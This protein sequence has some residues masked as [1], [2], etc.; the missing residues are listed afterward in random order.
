MILVELHL[1]NYKQYAGR[2]LIEF[3]SH[4]A[5][6]II[7]NNGA[8]K[9]T[10]F[11]AIEWCLYN[12][13]HIPT[14]EIPPRGGVGDTRVKL[15]L[16]DPRDGVRYVIERVR[17]RR[18]VEAEI[19]RADQPDVLIVKGSRD[20]T[21]YVK[22][23]LIGLGHRAFVSTF[24]TRQKELSFFGDLKET[25]RRRE[26]AQLLG[27]ETIRAAQAILG[28]DRKAARDDALLLTRQYEEERKDHDFVAEAAQAEAAI[29]AANAASRVAAEQIA[30]REAGLAEARSELERWNALERDD[31]AMASEIERLAGNLRA[32]DT[33]YRNAA[34]NLARLDALELD[35]QALLPRRDAEPAAHERLLTLD[36]DHERFLR[37]QS[38]AESARR[39]RST[40]DD[41]IRRARQVVQSTDAQ[42]LSLPGWL[43]DAA[44]DARPDAGLA[45]LIK[46]IDGLDPP[47]AAD[48]ADKLAALVRAID[49]LTQSQ[50]KA[51]QYQERLRHV[52]DDLAQK[53]ANGDPQMR[54]DAL[55]LARDDAHRAS[56]TALT[57][58]KGLATR[59]KELERT[60]AAIRSAAKQPECPTCRR[61]LPIAEA[62]TA[63]APLISQIKD[64]TEQQQRSEAERRTAQ[65]Q[66]TSAEAE[67]EQERARLLEIQGL[68]A[69][70]N[71]GTEYVRDATEDLQR[72]EDDRRLLRIAAGTRADP[73]PQDARG[74]AHFAEATRSL[75]TRRDTVLHLRDQLT[76]STHEHESALR[77]IAEVGDVRYDPLEHDRAKRDHGEIREAIA[78]LKQIEQDL[79]NRQRYNQQR[80]AAATAAEA[81]SR[82]LEAARG[83]RATI[84]FDPAQL[85]AAI[86]AEHEA[87]AE[88]RN[89]DRA[90]AAARHAAEAAVR[91]RETLIEHHQRIEAIARRAERRQ[92][93]HDELD[94]MY[95]E[96]GRF[97]QH[98]AQLVTPQLA[99]YAGELLAEVTDRTYDHVVFDEN[100]GLR[101][102][103]GPEHF[104]IDQFSGGE[105]DVAAL[106]AR[107][108]LSR[109]IGSQAA[110]PPRFLVL[111]E[112]F[113]SLDADRRA[114][115]LAALLQ[116]AGSDGPFRQL[117][118]ISHVDDVRISP[119]LDEV[120]RVHEV[121]GSSKV[122]NISRG[123]SVE[124]L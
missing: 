87:S 47:A 43:W 73:T 29:A 114:H 27:F 103:D 56:Q 67:L 88:A 95:R 19:Y 84:G 26:V 102:Y 107:L 120:W 71:S 96:F 58:G 8:G 22:R 25:E 81:S 116:L 106:C 110:H 92:R 90:A 42:T 48:H 9:T 40:I 113:G 69:S 61:P 89:A 41:V 57:H 49:L 62:E 94:R 70:L 76:Q 54:I 75:A 123:L 63:I 68:E 100:Y 39:S 23:R 38:Y 15:V 115:V 4:G 44:D 64:Y 52:T 112:V 31:A 55:G 80:E 3:P 33:D 30:L 66:I 101:I 118:I 17:R 37:L 50:R 83:Q 46:S 65:G 36:T 108:A 119:A 117:F 85:E 20:V 91:E 111:D 10:L 105:R 109:F 18:G 82:Q 60:V 13:R 93:E 6:G 78:R 1:E 124:D 24:F 11:E 121:D 104:S 2:H 35:R 28:L 77:Q 45:R 97:D 5:V 34:D 21:E 53:R 32:A 16:E 72:R 122:E 79:T 86:V 98:V 51:Q 99:D 7:G 59:I 14:D 74:A 12:P